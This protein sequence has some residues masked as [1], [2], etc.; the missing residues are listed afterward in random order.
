MDIIRYFSPRK[1][2]IRFFLLL[3]G[4][5]IIFYSWL[6]SFN[7]Q[8]NS[9]VFLLFDNS[10]SMTVQDIVDNE[11][12]IF[13]S[14]LATATKFS[15][16]FL[17]KYDFWHNFA[18]WSFASNL[19]LELPFSDDKIL[20]KNVIS[21]FSPIVYG[22]WSD[23][24][25][26]LENFS[27]IYKN[28]KNIDII[29]FSDFEFFQQKNIPKLPPGTRVF[30]VAIGTTSGGNMILEYDSFGKPIYKNF[31]N[32]IAISRISPD[33]IAD[34]SK[35]LNSPYFIVSSLKDLQNLDEKIIQF[36]ANRGYNYNFILNIL[37]YFALFIAI[38][39]NIYPYDKIK[40]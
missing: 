36:L 30:L 18:I 11:T 7:N 21:W 20:L 22:G 10:L 6:N 5:F 9:R 19:L 16:D 1:A 25:T 34:F 38:F 27:E 4:F 23:V 37:A 15:Q 28:S 26:A 24:F 17:Q 32:N 33:S 35:I 40:N 13:A 31:E 29:I 2:L 14:R 39:M 8:Q 12:G 3:F